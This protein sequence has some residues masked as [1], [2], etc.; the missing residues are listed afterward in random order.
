LDF[1]LV[2]TILQG[3]SFSFKNQHFCPG[4]DDFPLKNALFSCVQ[5]RWKNAEKNEIFK[6]LAV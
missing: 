1:W 5:K 2:F 6:I 3:L 4:Y